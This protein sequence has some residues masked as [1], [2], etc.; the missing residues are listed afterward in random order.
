VRRFAIV[1]AILAG[2]A[3]SL[4]IIGQGYSQGGTGYGYGNGTGN[5]TGSCCALASAY[6]TTDDGELDLIRD[7]RD[8]YLVT[9][10][11]GRGVV[12]LY[13]DVVSP[14][15]AHFIDDHPSI[16]PLARAALEPVVILSAA[17]VDTTTGE[18]AAIGGAVALLSA[19]VLVWIRRRRA[20]GARST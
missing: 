19:A 13:Y 5:W 3:L 8:R 9:N 18:K 20:R 16:K 6:T 15:L 7:F 12:V 1:L 10:P 4:V 17:A 2:L 14:P 11:V